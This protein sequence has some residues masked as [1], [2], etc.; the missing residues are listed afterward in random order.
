MEVVLE[1]GRHIPFTTRHT[2]RAASRN[3][4]VTRVKVICNLK[5]TRDT[6]PMVVRD[7]LQ[8]ALFV[9]GQE[10]VE[11]IDSEGL[12]QAARSGH[13]SLEPVWGFGFYRVIAVR[14]TPDGRQL[15]DQDKVHGSR[16]RLEGPLLTQMSVGPRI[17]RRACLTDGIGEN[18]HTMAFGPT[19]TLLILSPP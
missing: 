10:P 4:K 7:D 8:S 12:T 17:Q 6:S 5:V 2:I 13:L 11:E 18:P 16:V 3:L 15:V 1:I 9:R 14:E 19:S